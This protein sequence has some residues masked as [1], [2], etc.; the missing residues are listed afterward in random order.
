[1]IIIMIWSKFNFYH[2][3]LLN[4]SSCMIQSVMLF[5]RGSFFQFVRFL[6][7]VVGLLANV[8]EYVS[9]FTQE[10]FSNSLVNCFFSKND[11]PLSLNVEK[12]FLELK[13]CPYPCPPPPSPLYKTFHS[14]DTLWHL[15][16]LLFKETKQLKWM[17][18]DEQ[19]F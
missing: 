18:N 2:L 14:L 10:F 19:T 6:L 1:M 13:P 3:G 4:R 15:G 12:G 16:P 17:K 5:S 7:N 8:V 11:G 9:I